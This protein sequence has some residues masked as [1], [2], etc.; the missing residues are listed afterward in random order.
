MLAALELEIRQVAKRY[1]A[2]IED[3]RVKV[4]PRSG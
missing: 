4:Q 1:G 3:F 2:Q